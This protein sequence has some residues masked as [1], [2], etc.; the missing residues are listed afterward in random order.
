M[1]LTRSLQYFAVALASLGIVA[2][3]VALATT[4]AVEAQPARA[5]VTDVALHA[6]NMLAGQLLDAQGNPLAG[7]PV[8]VSQSNWTVA[9]TKTTAEGIFAVRNLKSGVYTIDAAGSQGTYRVWTANTAP[10]AAKPAI[11]M[12]HGDAARGQFGGGLLGAL[13]N[14]WVLGGIVAGAIAIP[15]ALDD[16]DAS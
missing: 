14:P 7:A 16:D 4:P 8:T 3:Q 2:P 6:D 1:K 12:V 13:G 10:P 15:I 9:E 11:L 5:A